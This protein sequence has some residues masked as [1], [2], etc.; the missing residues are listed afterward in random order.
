MFKGCSSLSS[1]DLST[2]DT[3]SVDNMDR[4]FED[5]IKLEYINLKNFLENEFLSIVNIF[6]NV[7][8]NVIVCLNEN[9]IRIKKEIVK[10]S[11]YIIDC[12]Y[13]NKEILINN[14]IINSINF[15]TEYIDCYNISLN[16]Q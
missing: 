9:S 14:S 13:N 1:L 15:D 5:C 10:K 4:M 6:N 8:D 7:P 3:S 12:S 11:N 2:F 16:E